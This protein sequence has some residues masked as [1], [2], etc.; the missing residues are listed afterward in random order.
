MPDAADEAELVALEAHA[1]ASPV[2]ETPA[3][4]LVAD[5]GFGNL[6]ASGK[7]LNGDDQGATVGF[8]GGEDAQHTSS[9]AGG[10]DRLRSAGPIPT[11]PD[12]L[13]G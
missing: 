2:A 12:P 7:S 11:G 5:D 9:V 1:G 3:S 6:Q 8:S 10:C 4:Q 13:L